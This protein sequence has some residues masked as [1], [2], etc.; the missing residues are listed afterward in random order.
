LLAL[1][2][3]VRQTVALLGVVFGT[4]AIFGIAI[5]FAP[6]RLTAA[7]LVGGAVLVFLLGVY[8]LRALQYREFSALVASVLSVVRHGRRVVQD[9]LRADELADAIADATSLD[10]VRELLE[11]VAGSPRIIDVELV[12]LAE[13]LHAHGPPGQ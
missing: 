3:T 1:G 2:C 10:D 7:L 8:G 13:G 12:E 4:V 6:A 11:S 5:A 9:K